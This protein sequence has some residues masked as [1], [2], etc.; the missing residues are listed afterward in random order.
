MTYS[1]QTVKNNRT[2]VERGEPIRIPGV[3]RAG[4]TVSDGQGTAVAGDASTTGS[5]AD[6]CKAV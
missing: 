3:V 5:L 2:A 6:N 1:S 4:F